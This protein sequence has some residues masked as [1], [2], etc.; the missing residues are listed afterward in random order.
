MMYRC[1]VGWKFINDIRARVCVDGTR[2]RLKGTVCIG[3]FVSVR[4]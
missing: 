3:V 2:I 1:V 4:V